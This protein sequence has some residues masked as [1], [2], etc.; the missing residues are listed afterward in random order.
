MTAQAAAGEDPSPGEGCAQESRIPPWQRQRQHDHHL[1]RRC[2]GVRLRFQ[3]RDLDSREWQEVPPGGSVDY[4]WEEPMGA[5][6]LRVSLDP[7]QGFKD[8]A[9]HQYSLD[10][11]KVASPGH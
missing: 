10:V 5:H 8:P 4:A 1:Q 11:I 6:K 2:E 3:Q 7:G 9:T